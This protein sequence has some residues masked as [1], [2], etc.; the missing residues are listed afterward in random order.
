MFE[1]KS[2]LLLS[3]RNSLEESSIA[4]SLEEG[5]LSGS[6]C[7]P[8][9]RNSFAVTIKA[10][11]SFHDFRASLPTPLLRPLRSFA[12][13]ISQRATDSDHPLG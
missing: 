4:Q 9:F 7:V 3:M 13:L 11:P 1:G 5:R 6:L 10:S 2:T 8:A 12:G